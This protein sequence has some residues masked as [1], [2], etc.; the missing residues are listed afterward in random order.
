MQKAQNSTPLPNFSG[1]VKALSALT[2]LDVFF[3]M[4]HVSFLQYAGVKPHLC[5]NPAPPDRFGQ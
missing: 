3:Y 1:Y 4:K 5:L 2:F